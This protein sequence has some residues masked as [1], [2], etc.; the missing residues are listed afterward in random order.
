MPMKM[1]WVSCWEEVANDELDG[2]V[3]SK[4]VNVPLRVIGIRSIAEICEQQKGI[5]GSR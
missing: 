1:Q 3:L 5:A 2:C 4:V